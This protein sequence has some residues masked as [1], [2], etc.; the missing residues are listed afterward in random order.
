MGRRVRSPASAVSR[1][2]WHIAADWVEA[3]APV[4]WA[5]VDTQLRQQAQRLQEL[6]EAARASGIPVAEPLVILVDNVP[7]YGPDL[8]FGQARHDSGFYTPQ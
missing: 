8:D 3:F 4:L 7:V 6:A 1:N 5:W 2:A